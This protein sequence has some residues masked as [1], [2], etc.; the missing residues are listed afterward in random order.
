MA[1]FVVCLPAYCLCLY[2]IL[3]VNWLRTNCSVRKVSIGRGSNCTSNYTVSVTGESTGGEEGCHNQSWDYS[4]WTGVS[5]VRRMCAEREIW[6]SSKDETQVSYLT[7]RSFINKQV[8]EPDLEPI[9]TTFI[10]TAL[11]SI[12]VSKQPSGG[13]FRSL[14]TSF[15]LSQVSAREN[16]FT[17][18]SESES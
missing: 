12:K 15:V 8:K 7:K 9:L 1:N 17:K 14:S 11:R 6:D 13:L 10:Y 16:W 18:V 5:S 2:Y 3:S 4:G